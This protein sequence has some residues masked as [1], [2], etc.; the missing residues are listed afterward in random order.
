MLF[1]SGQWLIHDIAVES[2]GDKE[3]NPSI[4]SVR[5]LATALRSVSLFLDAY[6][7]S[8]KEQLKTVCKPAFF[9]GCIE[10]SDLSIVK[11]LNA[12]QAA[13]ADYQIK[14]ESGLVNFVVTGPED[15]MRLSL[16][17]V[18]GADSKVPIQ[19][20]VDEYFSLSP[21]NWLR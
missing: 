19:Y 12:Q 11:L 21:S 16:V 20:L 6:Q 2:R 18:D 13:V 17:R 15:V 1:R 8:D 14:L 3:N 10:P 4:P 7:T 5:Q 9:S